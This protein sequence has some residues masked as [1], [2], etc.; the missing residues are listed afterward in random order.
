MFTVLVFQHSCTKTVLW[1]RWAI[2]IVPVPR[3]GGRRIPG[4]H[5]SVRWAELV[6]SR[7]WWEILSQKIRWKGIKEGSWCWRV[8]LPTYAHMV[9][10]QPHAMHIHLKHRTH[11]HIHYTQ[12]HVHTEMCTLLPI[13]PWGGGSLKNL[14]F[15]N[16]IYSLNFPELMVYFDPD[17]LFPEFLMELF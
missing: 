14:I 17:L 12:K 5:L 10:S 16:I 3:N 9:H 1:W 6:S 8:A 7:D 11:I 4:A 13:Q 2:F 15:S